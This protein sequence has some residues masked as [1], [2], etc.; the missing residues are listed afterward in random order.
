MSQGITLGMGFVYEDDLLSF[1]QISFQPKD[2]PLKTT[3]SLLSKDKGLELHSH[4]RF[5]P[6]DNFVFNF[7][8]QDTKQ[9]FDLNWGIVSGL[10]FIAKGNSHKESLECWT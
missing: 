1:S 4:L 8:S 6:A 5:Q 2:I 9:K 10:T 7:H 3:F